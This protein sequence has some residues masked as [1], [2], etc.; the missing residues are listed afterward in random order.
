MANFSCLDRLPKREGEGLCYFQF[1]HGSNRITGVRINRPFE[2]VSINVA[3]N[4]ARRETER[5]REETEGLRETS[6][7]Q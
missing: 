5:Q 3:M 2:A 6:W 7:E 4:T 1:W